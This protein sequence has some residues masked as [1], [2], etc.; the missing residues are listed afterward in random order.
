MTLDQ[1]VGV[2]IPVPQPLQGVL[3]EGVGRFF[4]NLVSLWRGDPKSPL[5]G[6]FHF[7]GVL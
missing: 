5:E 7:G 6:V 2:R 1:M 4:F 3:L